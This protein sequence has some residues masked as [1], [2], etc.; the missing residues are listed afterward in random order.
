MVYNDLYNSLLLT[1]FLY[2]EGTILIKDYRGMHSL[3]HI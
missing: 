3:L 2:K 1:N